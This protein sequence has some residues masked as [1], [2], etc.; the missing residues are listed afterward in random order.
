VG[1][2]SINRVVYNEYI[3]K[4]IK[5]LTL[6]LTLNG[7]LAV[8]R[9]QS[10]QTSFIETHFFMWTPSDNHILLGKNI[11]QLQDW[12]GFEI[13]IRDNP[14]SRGLGVFDV[15][16]FSMNITCLNTTKELLDPI[17]AIIKLHIIE[18][19]QFNI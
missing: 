14:D 11:L 7:H 10:P 17:V 15:E 16:W 9:T 19:Q 2:F 4:G 5:V 6:M 3:C 13:C 8:Q 12:Q 18:G 1:P